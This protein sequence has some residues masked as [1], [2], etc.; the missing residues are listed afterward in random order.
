MVLMG[1]WYKY[2][3]V[4]EEAVDYESLITIYWSTS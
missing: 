1:L 4:S 3:D 2:T